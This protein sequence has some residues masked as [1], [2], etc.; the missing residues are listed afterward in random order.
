MCRQWSS[1]DE[2]ELS[3]SGCR[4]QAAVQESCH[5]VQEA[6]QA[7]A[8]LAAREDGSTDFSA[9][10]LMQL[11]LRQAVSHVRSLRP[12]RKAKGC[13]PVGVMLAGVT[14]DSVLVVH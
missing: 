4:L 6:S 3:R 7:A 11:P 13:A 5:A 9:C 12:R 10:I 1:G 2:T 8:P 14:R